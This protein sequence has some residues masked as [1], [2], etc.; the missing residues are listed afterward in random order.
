M[1]MGNFPFPSS[2]LT[3]GK[4]M[5]PAFPVQKMCDH[6]HNLDKTDDYNLMVAMR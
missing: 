3:H 4:Y 2:Y 1:A 6:M 5:L